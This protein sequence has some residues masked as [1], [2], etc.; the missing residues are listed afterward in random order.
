MERQSA[1][2]ECFLDLGIPESVSPVSWE[3]SV[4]SLEA[5]LKKR[6]SK[7]FREDGKEWD[8]SLE[9]AADGG[10]AFRERKAIPVHK[11]YEFQPDELA[12]PDWRIKITQESLV[13]NVCSHSRD[14]WQWAQFRSFSEEIRQVFY[15]GLGLSH[16]E[17]PSVTCIFAFDSEH[18]GDPSLATEKWVEVKELLA[19]FSVMPTPEGF[20][21]YL[22][23]YLCDQNWRCRCNGCEYVVVSQ[24]KTAPPQDEKGP[25]SIF[26]YL[27][28]ASVENTGL[29]KDLPWDDWHALLKSS[30]QC[31]LTEK[32]CRLLAEDFA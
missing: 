5:Y 7:V 30:F 24:V 6:S 4:D 31:H 27:T 15:N 21:S 28:V 8:Y 32:A 1:L 13:I 17:K 20:E 29:Q 25:L 11:L 22:P 12:Q 14:K 3:K 23:K 16:C 9:S 18:V 10:P 19:P 26:L 2:I